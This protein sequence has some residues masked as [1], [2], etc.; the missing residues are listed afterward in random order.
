MQVYTQEARV[1]VASIMCVSCRDTNQFTISSSQVIKLVG[2]CVDCPWLDTVYTWTIT[3]DDGVALPI[4]LHTTTTGGDRRNLVVRSSVLQAGYAY[5]FNDRFFAVQHWTH[6]T[7]LFSVS[8][9]FVSQQQ[10]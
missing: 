9:D 1:L 2:G 8:F 6:C 3:R 7:R 10:C 4:N 5:R